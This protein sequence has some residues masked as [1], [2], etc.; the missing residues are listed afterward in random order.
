MCLAGEVQ[1]TERVLWTTKWNLSCYSQTRLYENFL[2]TKQPKM[3]EG[4]SCQ[5]S[6]PP[7]I[8]PYLAIS[9]PAI[10]RW[11]SKL[12]ALIFSQR[13]EQ[14]F[15]PLLRDNKSMSCFPVPLW[16][17][18]MP[19][20]SLMLLCHQTPVS[21]QSER[22]QPFFLPINWKKKHMQCCDREN[23]GIISK[24]RWKGTKKEIRI[25]SFIM[26]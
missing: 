6:P 26:V 24:K 1:Q 15:F 10:S 18:I 9:L 17:K 4:V 23:P 11:W 8:I 14:L 25:E 5:I 12:H 3:F 22:T 13:P 20:P 2:Q 21:T 7:I 16:S 19:A